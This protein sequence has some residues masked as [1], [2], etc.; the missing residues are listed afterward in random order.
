MIGVVSPV[1][2]RKHEAEVVGDLEHSADHC[3]PGSPAFTVA[4][5]CASAGSRNRPCTL[6][7]QLHRVPV[8]NVVWRLNAVPST[9]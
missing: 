5:S 8:P 1:D 4:A 9:D 7:K 6:R 3:G 2:G